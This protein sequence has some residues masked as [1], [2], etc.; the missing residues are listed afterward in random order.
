MVCVS[1]RSQSYIVLTQNSSGGASAAF[2]GLSMQGQ[3]VAE[4]AAKGSHAS[5][6]VFFSLS[7]AR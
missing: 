1:K 5:L 3:Y 2:L 7:L 6:P 4:C